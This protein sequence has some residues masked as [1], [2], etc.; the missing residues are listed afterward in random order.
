MV[1]ILEIVVVLLVV[2]QTDM[3]EAV[4]V[5]IERHDELWLDG[6]DIVNLLHCQ[7]ECLRVVYRL[8]G[9]S[10][11]IQLYSGKQRR[12]RLHCG[13]YGTTQTVS[14]ERAIEYI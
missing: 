4:A 11:F 7:R 1:K 12:M 3:E 9:F 10:L 6:L 5:D 13:F 14:V 2:Q 8:K